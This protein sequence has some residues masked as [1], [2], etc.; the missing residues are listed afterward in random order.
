M[1]QKGHR[2]GR[3]S[4]SSLGSR[5]GISIHSALLATER[6]IALVELQQILARLEV[7]SKAE[8]DKLEALRDLMQGPNAADMAGRVSS[9]ISTSNPVQTEE[10]IEQ[11]KAII[12][13][14]RTL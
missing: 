14:L 2:R 8:F 12:E 3:S 6:N 7:R 4:T 9:L 10:D 5:L 13:R 11:T 1:P